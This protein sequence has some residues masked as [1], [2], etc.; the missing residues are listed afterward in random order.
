M[1]NK[2]CL[3]TGGSGFLGI[4]LCRYLLARGYTLRTLDIAP[5]EY[6]ERNV[7]EVLHG[8]IRDRSAVDAA[9]RG[10]DL[11]VHAAAALP[12]SSPD[13]IFSTDAD[14]TRIVLESAF[15][16][17]VSRVIFTSSTSVYG[18]PD[19]HPL[20]EEDSLHGVGPYGEAKIEAERHCREFRAAGHCVTVL[21]PKS[22]VGP[23]RLG[24][25]ELLYDWAAAGRNFPVLGS[26]D[27]LYQLLDVEDLCAVIHRCATLDADVVNDSFNVG[28]K[29]FCTMRENF[30][31]VLDRA[32]HGKRVIGF[33]AR[34]V[35]IALRLL[36]SLHLSPIYQWI[37]ATAAQESFVSIE[38]LEQKLGYVPR[39][40]NQQALLRNF[41]WY[42]EHRDEYRGKTGVSHRVPWKR[43][44]LKLAEVFF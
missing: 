12:L 44:A 9:M 25:F 5:F 2:V 20:H 24:V 3:V 18:I 38:R 14:G 21:R 6:P 15:R 11:V 23:E 1:T 7:V 27:N 26:G 22:F 8:D 19:H 29:D 36:E 4:N 42:L 37:Y 32:G 43:G 17:G 30:Q 28:A 41:D 10:I 33:P 39:Y 40:S 31:A 13:D 16:N 35:I 34:P